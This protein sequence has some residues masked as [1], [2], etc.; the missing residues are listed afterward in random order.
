MQLPPRPPR[1]EHLLFLGRKRYLSHQGRPGPGP[2]RRQRL[3]AWSRG[4][5]SARGVEGMGW[6]RQR[7]L[8]RLDSVLW[9]L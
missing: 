1:P 9:Q 4:P 3:E 5:C 6:C 8:A 2:S 7:A